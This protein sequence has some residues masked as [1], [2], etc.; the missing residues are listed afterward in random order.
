M[1]RILFLKLV[2]VLFILHFNTT[3]YS[4]NNYYIRDTVIK[5]G[6]KLEIESG[7]T[8][9]K[10]CI[11]KEAG[12]TIHYTPH[13]ISEYGF[14]NGQVFFSKR[15][16]LP[17]S[18]QTV[19]LER[20]IE[21]S[22]TLYYYEGEKYKTFFIS[23]DS[24]VLKELPYFNSKENS[25]YRKQLAELSSECNQLGDALKLVRY[26]KIEITEFFK[27]LNKCESKHF[28]ALRYGFTNGLKL[29][30]LNLANDF[31]INKLT[32]MNYQFRA[33]YN[34]GFF[35][36]IPIFPSALS[37]YTGV[38]L[39]KHGFS[40]F[41]HIDENDVDFVLNITSI[42]IPLAF[43]YTLPIVD[44]R[45]YLSAGISAIYHI[46][47]KAEIFETRNVNNIIQLGTGYEVSVLDNYQ[48][49]CII[50]TGMEKKLDYRHYLS[51]GL[52]YSYVPGNTVSFGSSEFS[53]TTRIS[54]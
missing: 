38:N 2:F 46:K 10:Y 18:L 17:D 8:N 14:D 49:G 1:N 50:E 32:L 7:K 27:R 26:N 45:P 5:Y 30:R 47:N 12:S 51:L 6:V 13:Q 35:A 4:Q 22:F 44:Y 21:G 9:S 40:Y 24:S 3:T 39:S 25:N 19:F 15:V 42:D 52:K 37:I 20:L 48:Y 23:K 11:A 43:K 53:L 34:A 29:L 33:G 28:P 54:F 16:Q 36:D 41:E 31:Y